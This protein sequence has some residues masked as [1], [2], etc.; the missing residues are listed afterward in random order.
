L[1]T[2]EGGVVVG[3][4]LFSA[5]VLERIR[6]R[7]RAE[8]ELTRAALARGV[9]EW[10]EWTRPNGKWGEMGCRVALRK[11]EQRGVLSLPAPR[12]AIKR[13]PGPNERRPLIAKTPIDSELKALGPV[14]LVGVTGGRSKWL[15]L[16]KEM[17]SAHHYLGYQ[18]LVGAQ[19]RYLI[20]CE[21][22]WLGAI[23]FSAAAWQL[24]ARDRFIGWSAGA[25]RA[26]LSLVVCNSRFLLLPWV[27][28]PNLASKVLALVAACVEREW[29]AAYGLPARAARNVRG[30]G[31]LYGRLLPGR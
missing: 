11:L 5:A 20:R 13:G 12:C 4:R 6:A 21:R 3:G 19:L 31:A 24:A 27:Q 23:S 10:L 26:H 14:E 29:P 2:V 28:V 30:P 8:A 9:C 17:V 25:R 22:G 1:V 7:V 15:R 16:W 18:P